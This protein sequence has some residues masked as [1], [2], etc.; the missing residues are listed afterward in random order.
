MCKN[1]FNIHATWIPKDVTD[2][3]IQAFNG[4]PHFYA[5]H[6]GGLPFSF[7]WEPNQFKYFF[8]HWFHAYHSYD[9][10]F[11][12]QAIYEMKLVNLARW[13]DFD[14]FDLAYSGVTSTRA[15]LIADMRLFGKMPPSKAQNIDLSEHFAKQVASAKKLSASRAVEKPRTAPSFSVDQGPKGF[16]QILYKQGPQFL[17]GDFPCFRHATS[18]KQHEA[19][20]PCDF[21]KFKE[22]FNE[23]QEECFLPCNFYKFKEMLS[24]HEKETFLPCDFYKFKDI[25][26]EDQKETLLPCNFYKF[27]EMLSEHQKQTFLPCNFYKYKEMLSENQK[28]TFL[29]C[30]FYKFKEIFSESRQKNFLPIDFYKFKE[31]FREESPE[32]FLPIDF[33]KYKEYTNDE[34]ALEYLPRDFFKYVETIYPK[35]SRTYLPK[36]FYRFEDSLKETQ[37]SFFMPGDFPHFEKLLSEN[38]HPGSP[39]H[40]GTTEGANHNLGARKFFLPRDFHSFYRTWTREDY[41]PQLERKSLKKTSKPKKSSRKLSKKHRL[42]SFLRSLRP[43]RVR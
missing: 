41:V 10:K 12:A 19:F 7:S 21:Y 3:V 11:K 24:E 22:I 16:L 8:F 40:A 6:T 36:D 35:C 30:N 20:L 13:H 28:V 39:R 18:E 1:C 31:I 33:Y 32:S 9:L 4:V 17:P 37:P 29:P 2:L 42:V 38:C 25:F 43:S 26:N 23:D 15:V 27:K 14:T 5:R 34:Q